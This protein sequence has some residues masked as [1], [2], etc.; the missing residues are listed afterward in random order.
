MTNITYAVK[1]IKTPYLV[2]G[3]S[4]EHC[5]E[6]LQPY[7]GPVLIT[8]KVRFS[9]GDKKTKWIENTKDV[10]FSLIEDALSASE[11]DFTNRWSFH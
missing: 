11:T 6:L 2:H 1:E 3:S 4:N 10:V 7:T 5:A 9:L 8:H